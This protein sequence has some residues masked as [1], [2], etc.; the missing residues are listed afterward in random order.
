MLYIP[1]L[2]FLHETTLL[3]QIE[4]TKRYIGLADTSKISG[5][6]AMTAKLFPKVNTPAA[7]DKCLLR[8]RLNHCSRKSKT[9]EMPFTTSPWS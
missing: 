2:I 4:H 3:P 6:G 5:C 1:I 7:F 9:M 8:R